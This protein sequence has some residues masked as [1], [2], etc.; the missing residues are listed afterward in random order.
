MDKKTTITFGKVALEAERA[1]LARAGT[2]G[3]QVMA[4]E[5]MVERLAGGFLKI[6]DIMT[7]RETVA[8]CLDDTDLGELD[9]IKDMPGMTTACADSLMAWWMS[10]LS[11]ADFE[12]HPRMRAIFMLEAAVEQRLPVNLKKPG[13]MVELACERIAIAPKVLG[14]VVFLGMTDLHPVWRP[15]VEA[16]ASLDGYTI[17]WDGGP[18]PVPAWLSEFPE[19]KVRFASRPAEAPSLL[20]E[21]AS[22][23]RHEVLESLRWAVELLAAGHKGEDIAIAAVSTGAYEGIIHTISRDSDIE[24]HMSNGIPA[25][26]TQT[27]QE[28]AALADILIRGI[29]HKRVRRLYEVGPESKAFEGIPRDW[30][31]RIPQDASLLTVERWKRLLSRNDMADVKPH[32]DRVIDDVSKGVK[33]AEE[34]G[35]LFLSDAAQRLWTRALRSGPASALDQTLRGMR[36]ATGGTS[37]DKVCFMSARD[38][39]AAPR[40]FVR[41]LGLTSRQWPRRDGEDSLIPNYIVPTRQ[42]SPM[43]VSEMDRRDFQSIISTTAEKVVFSWPRMD[44]D[45]REL[46]P[47]TLVPTSLVGSAVRLDRARKARYAISEGDRLFMR[48]FE[49]ADTKA[50]RRA[51]SASVNWFRPS[52]TAHDGLIKPNH[53]RIEAV[54]DQVQSATSLQK[55]IRDPLGFVWRYALGFTAP[56]FDDEPILVDARM[57]GNVVHAILKLAVEKLNRKGGFTRAK[58]AMLRT[59]VH[60]ARLEVGLRMEQS[61]PV[62]PMLV[63]SQTLDRA[64]DIAVRTLIFDYGTPTDAVSF[65]EVPFG[66]EREWIREE[67]PWMADEA[68]FIPGT[69]I[70]IRGSLDRLDL[71]ASTSVANVTDYKTGKTPR[72]P[73]EMGI[74]GGRELQRALYGFAVQTLLEGCETIV[75]ALYYPLTDTFVPMD[76]IEHHMAEVSAA[77]ATA[78]QTLRAGHAFPGIGAAE[79]YN[80]MMFGFPARATTVYLAEKMQLIGTE[81]E[82]LRKVWETK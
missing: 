53:P 57:F 19:G 33:F 4:F 48:T 40:K 59:E 79:E 30:V 25:L 42:L 74:N 43:S 13:D 50:A 21:T 68:V 44:G 72:S 8:A 82:G 23:A 67:L 77:V 73:A 81:F 51:K 14:D 61:Q 37:L 55:M 5:H 39:V 46:R 65:A 35:P 56:E 38:L 52:L 24:I 63:W 3:G 76:D 11:N 64:E 71:S 16:M 7:L 69:N 45:G 2:I 27:G 12:K 58:E 62:P 60:K 9:G 75:S 34:A 29:S 31:K 17:T 36:V 80:D 66:D 70:R 10:G 18:Y 49:F 22:D 54:F 26:Q 41:L 1:A 47:S 78:Q 15:V 28:C 20:A 6:V 32:L